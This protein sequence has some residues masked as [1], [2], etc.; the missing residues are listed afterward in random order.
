MLRGS[1]DPVSVSLTGSPGADLVNKAF[2]FEIPENDR[3]ATEEDRRRVKAFH[4]QQVGPT[5]E[6]TAA[7]QT[8]V[9]DCSTEEYLQRS[10]E[11][12][13]PSTRCEPCLYLEWYS[14]NGRVVLEVPASRLTFLE[15][16]QEKKKLNYEEI[17]ELVEKEME[18]QA[19]DR[20]LLSDG[21]GAEDEEEHDLE[22]MNVDDLFTEEPDESEKEDYGL[23]PDELDRELARSSR[24]LEREMS[25][26]SEDDQKEMEEMELLDDLIE[27]EDGVPMQQVVKGI[28]LPAPASIATDEEAERALK[29][30]L[31][32]VALSGVAF[33]VCEHCTLRDAYRIFVV[34]VWSKC[35]MYPQLRGTGWVQ[36]FGTADYC[37][38]CGCDP[39]DASVG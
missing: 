8:K 31:A 33:D 3:P 30:A 16:P 27:N 28:E 5:G 35:K 13:P 1:E 32:Q 26:M 9:F 4:R 14:Q 17:A 25:G 12:N 18:A 20:E 23:I 7:R 38:Q 15:W 24:R 22:E 10:E 29:V 39:E 6:M 19:K 2:E 21:G 11:G 34:K 36:H 37:R